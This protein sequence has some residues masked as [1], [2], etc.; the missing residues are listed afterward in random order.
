MDRRDRDDRP[1]EEIVN[2]RHLDQLAIDL[3]MVSHV[4]NDHIVGI[5]KLFRRLKTEIDHAVPAPALALSLFA[6]FRSREQDTFRDK[7]LAALRN[8]FGGHAVRPETQA[9]A[10]R[11]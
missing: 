7:V 8:E 2:G 9:G 3:V 6:R 1:R 10:Q 5:K 11:R 4:D